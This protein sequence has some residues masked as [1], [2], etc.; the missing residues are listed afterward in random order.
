MPLKLFSFL[1]SFI[2]ILSGLNAQLPKV[3]SGRIERISDFNSQF[4]TP[5]NIDIW[6]PADYNPNKKYAVLYM[7]DG[8]MLFDSNLTWNKQEWLVDDIVSKL[9]TSHKII[10]CIVVGI[11]NGGKTR[12]SDYF[13]EKPYQSLS[14]I[15]KDSITAQLKQKARTETEFM[16]QSDNYLK[17]IVQELKPQIDAQ[18]ATY[19]DASHTFMAGSSMGGLISMYALCEYP[20]IFGGVACLSTHWPGVFATENNPIPQAFLNY[21]NLNFPKNTQSKIYFDYGDQ[22]LDALY[23]PLQHKIDRVMQTK[24][25][26]K[27]QWQ[28]RF[29]KGSDHSEKSW[30]AR[31][32]IPLLFLLGKEHFRN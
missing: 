10:P 12:H 21:L 6:L 1:A 29:F 13:P 5:R 11:W 25:I 9:I 30:S 31:L 17:F 16:P 20:T 22:T 19:T 27:D 14:A 2:I 23:P 24:H 7:N 3:V 4:V 18:Y 8:Q 15:E 32:D 28:T 26:S